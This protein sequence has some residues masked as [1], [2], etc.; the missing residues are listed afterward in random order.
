MSDRTYWPL[1]ASAT[2]V[3]VEDVKGNPA[4]IRLK[5]QRGYFHSIDL[6]DRTRPL[7]NKQHQKSVSCLQQFITEV[8]RYVLLACTPQS[9]SH[10]GSS[11]VLAGLTDCSRVGNK[12]AKLQHVVPGLAQK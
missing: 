11:S 1:V 10:S 8:C 2:I 9:E 4:H 3:T 5:S 6:F 12:L 7:R